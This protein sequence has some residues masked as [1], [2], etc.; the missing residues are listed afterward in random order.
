MNVERDNYLC[1]CQN[2]FVIKKYYICRDEGLNL[3][4]QHALSMSHIVLLGH[5]RLSRFLNRYVL[6]GRNY[7]V[8]LLNIKLCFDFLRTDYLEHFLSLDN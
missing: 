6:K 3:V 5:V 8:N 4:M 7:E 1:S 2:F